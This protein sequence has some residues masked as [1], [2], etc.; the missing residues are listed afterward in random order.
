MKKII[1]LLLF[2]VGLNAQT[3][4]D[5]YNTGEYSKAIDVFKTIDQPTIEDQIVLAKSYCAKGMNSNCV[6]TY[7]AAL[8]NAEPGK[9]VVAKFN[10]AKLLKNQKA[11]K[12]SDS[13]YKELLV[14]MPDNAEFHYQR[15]KIAEVLDQEAYH[16]HFLKAL[17]Y[18]PTHIK[19][20]QEASIY[21]LKVDNFKKATEIA[22]KALQNVPN[23]PGLIGVLAQISY[24]QENWSES[25][26]YILQL[27]QLKEDLPVFI[28]KLKGNN[29]LKL[30]KFN[31]AAN[32]YKVAFA[33][34][35]KDPEI[36]LKLGEIYLLE[37][38]PEKAR[39]YLSFYNLLR[40]T[41]MWEYNY[42]MGQYFMQKKSPQMAFRYFELTHQENVNHEAAQYYRAVAA[43]N[44]MEDKSKA[45]D[46]YT[47]YIQ[48]WQVEKD[49]KYIELALRRAQDIRE[50]LFMED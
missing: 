17:T 36:C 3:L 15:G 31:D 48:T 39:R 47:N 10:Y 50:E 22:T 37:K 8:Q 23:T 1:V 2:S 19:S 41:S 46:Y 11:Y 38:Q 30:N 35:N 29:Y 12:P 6:G 18:D 32:A 44:F 49:A 9:Y 4:E 14:E 27:E 5:Y 24:K 34:D 33:M 45:L 43:D 13:I 26:G 42:Q 21:F 7:Q 40:D 16:Q 28:Y 25:L 20:A